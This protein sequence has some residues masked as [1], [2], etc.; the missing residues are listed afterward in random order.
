MNWALGRGYSSEEIHI[1]AGDDWCHSTR[2]RK[3]GAHDRCASMPFT[4]IQLRYQPIFAHAS[5]YDSYITLST[6]VQCLRSRSSISILR[7][8]V[9]TFKC[10][11]AA[12]SLLISDVASAV[13]WSPQAGNRRCENLTFP[14]S[15]DCLEVL[16]NF[17]ILS[18]KAEVGDPR[19]AIRCDSAAHGRGLEHSS[20]LGAVE[21]VD[22]DGDEHGYEQRNRARLQINLPLGT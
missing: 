22:Q 19:F 14:P 21:F 4:H 18:T 7:I 16:S 17:S 6:Y 20:C 13:L 8:L 3:S 15:L 10:I 5:L 2:T 12:C 1:K 11:D 9:M